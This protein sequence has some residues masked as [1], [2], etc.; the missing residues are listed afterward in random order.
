MAGPLKK[1]ETS[2]AAKA[3]SA[4]SPLERDFGFPPPES[5]PPES[6]PPPAKPAA[7]FVV[8]QPHGF[9]DESTGEHRLWLEGHVVTDPAIVELLAERGAELEPVPPAE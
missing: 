8:R 4:S 9:I 6:N 1:G 2:G 3:A 5:N 7:A